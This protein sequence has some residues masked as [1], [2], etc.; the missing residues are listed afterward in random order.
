MTCNEIREW[1]GPY[2][3]EA[4]TP[5]ERRSVDGHVA[6]CAACAR[7]LAALRETVQLLSRPAVVQVPTELW[8]TIEQRLDAPQGRRRPSVMFSFRWLAAVAAVV[9]IAV[10]L[11]LFAL[12]WVPDGVKQAQAAQIDF[13]VLLDGLHANPEKAFDTFLDRYSAKPVS[14]AE[15]KQCG[16]GC[17]LNFD[18]PEVLPGGFRFVSSYTLQFGEKHGVAARYMRDGE[19]LGLLFHQPILKEQF[20][21]HAD[22]DCIVGQH[23]GHAVEVGGWSLVHLTD[24]TTCHCVLS[25]LNQETELPA[26]MAVIAPGAHDSPK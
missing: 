21:T 3:D 19:L 8:A 24:A 13:G 5:A 14:A 22:R 4:A 26:I 16:C 20:G 12:P 17:Q 2:V 10:G 15:A 23:R 6:E 25:R 7:E 9:A 1:L 18:I 11:G